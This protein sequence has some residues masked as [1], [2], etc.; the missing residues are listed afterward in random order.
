MRSCTWFTM[1]ND[2]N[3]VSKRR[4]KYCYDKDGSPSDIADKCPMGYGFCPSL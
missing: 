1:N 2:P 4:A 3:R